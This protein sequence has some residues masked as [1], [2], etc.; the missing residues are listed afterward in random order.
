M[1]RAL[2]VC[3]STY[4]NDPHGLP[5]LRGPQ[6]DGLVMW[7]ALTNP[8]S[9]L[10]APENVKVLF[11]ADRETILNTTHD[12][13]ERSGLSDILLF[14]FSGHA[15]LAGTDLYFCG[16]DARTV[17]IATYGVRAADVSASMEKSRA[18]NIVVLLDCCYGGAFKGDP[19]AENKLAGVG[20]FV[21]SAGSSLQVALDSQ[22]PMDASPFTAN[23]VR[24]LLEAGDEPSE[25]VNVDALYVRIDTLSNDALRP[26]KRFDGSGTV[27]IAR[28]LST[29]R[30]DVA[31]LSREPAD[32]LV[33]ATSDSGGHHPSRG[34]ST[35]RWRRRRRGDFSQ[36]D[37]MFSLPQFLWSIAA[38]G[39]ALA[40]LSSGSIWR[41]NVAGSRDVL[42][43]FLIIAG[44]GASIL[45]A[46]AIV[47]LIKML[48]RGK[49]PAKIRRLTL[50]E[51]GGAWGRA[52]SIAQWAAC[53]SMTPLLGS[54]IALLGGVDPLWVIMYAIFL[55]LC[56]AVATRLVSVGDSWLFSSNLLIALAVVVP[57]ES[58]MS[59]SGF[60]S[61][62][63]DLRGLA[64]LICASVGVVGWAF[65]FPK[66]VA[67]VQFV[68]L[69]LLGV[70]LM[71]EALAM[72][73]YG[74]SASAPFMWIV[75]VGISSLAVALLTGGAS[76]LGHHSASPRRVA[77]TFVP[78][79][80][81]TDAKKGLSSG[82]PPRDIG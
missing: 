78:T 14:Y 52:G 71:G 77:D 79:T 54:P 51:P 6:R 16:R 24:A 13:F 49:V 5:T 68:T 55:V 17:Q 3:N 10:F 2:L 40:N 30:P 69:I 11:E 67:L 25:Y 38:I 60:T 65:S 72:I 43:I 48:V 7:S 23:L 75:L 27:R 74:W 81:A 50:Q 44:V 15:V 76:P 34:W 64:I 8:H 29:D 37:V 36:G 45:A 9:G 46:V 33:E 26:R 4:P 35:T 56:V 28:G 80:P 32:S 21:I 39:L 61:G 58:R 31:A 53:V 66:W 22:D 41:N 20:R 73:R 19:G 63:T 59:D 42:A 70:S 18:S 62:L 57:L 12:F 1:Y 47:D 82:V